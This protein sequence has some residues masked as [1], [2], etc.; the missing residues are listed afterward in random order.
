MRP[1]PVV[2]R[3]SAFSLQL[4]T[5]SFDNINNLFAG[6][7]SGRAALTLSHLSTRV[8][9]GSAGG[10][11]NVV[12]GLAATSAESV[13][14]VM[15]LTKSLSTFSLQAVGVSTGH[16]SLDLHYPPSARKKKRID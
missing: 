16:Q 9:A 15:L 11:L 8:S 12:G 10:L 13:R 3:R 1:V 14:L 7:Q 4:S 5:N 2:R 6:A